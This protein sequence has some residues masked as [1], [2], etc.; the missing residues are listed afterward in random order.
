MSGYD[1]ARFT[2]E[3]GTLGDNIAHL[4]RPHPH[5]TDFFESPRYVA[6]PKFFLI[7]RRGNLANANQF[8]VK[9]F[10]QV[11]YELKSVSYPRRAQQACD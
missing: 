1:N 10:A 5:K 7:R 8:R 11:I 2:R 4:V 3:T 6:R 9:L